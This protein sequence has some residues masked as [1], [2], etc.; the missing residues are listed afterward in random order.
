[1][2]IYKWT[3]VKV[4]KLLSYA[5]RHKPEDLG[6][7][8]DAAG[9][10]DVTTVLEALAKRGFTITR[11]DLQHI[12]DTDDK[13]RY[14]FSVEGLK[15][16]ACQ[17]H[18]V[19]NVDLGLAAVKPPSVLWHGTSLRFLNRILDQGLLPMTRNHVHLSSDMEIAEEVGSRHGQLGLLKVYSDLMFQDG[20]KFYLSANEVWLTAL[21]PVDYLEVV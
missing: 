1:M 16:R 15:I 14:A 4:S 21:V 3:E 18:S 19:K 8:L 13:K 11:E 20:Y 9:Y 6:L 10:A 7:V 17:G 12:V 2:P 5:L